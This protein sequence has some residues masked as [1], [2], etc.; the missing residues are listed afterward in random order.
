[1]LTFTQIRVE[2]ASL[3]CMTL[4]HDFKSDPKCRCGG[5]WCER[6]REQS[7]AGAA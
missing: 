3:V 5:V 4:G 6:K 2:A 7:M 1:M